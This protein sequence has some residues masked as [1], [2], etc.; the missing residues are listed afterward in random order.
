MYQR[1]RTNAGESTISA[2]RPSVLAASAN[3][4]LRA[5]HAFPVER[6]NE[7]RGTGHRRA[8]SLARA[9]SLLHVLDGPRGLNEA[10]E[11]A[12]SPGLLDA[13]LRLGRTALRRLAGPSDCVPS[14]SLRSYRVV[15]RRSTHPDAWRL[16]RSAGV[17]SGV[18]K[19]PVKQGSSEQGSSEGPRGLSIA[20]R[21][22]A[23][24]RRSP[25]LQVRL[26]RPSMCVAVCEL[27]LE[28]ARRLRHR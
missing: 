2:T 15:A 7:H 6:T 1:A 25:L 27:T 10:V 12:A 23:L 22:D 24:R 17:H 9:R 28:D 18:T 4:D 5:H 3:A 26:D 19:R 21:S 16:S 20:S 14:Q 13:R 11:S 8:E